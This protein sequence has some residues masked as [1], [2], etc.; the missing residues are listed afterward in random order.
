MG[1][2]SDRLSHNAERMPRHVSG[3]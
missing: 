1:R 2:V 3:G